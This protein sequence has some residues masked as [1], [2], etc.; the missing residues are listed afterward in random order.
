MQKQGKCTYLCC[1]VVTKYPKQVNVKHGLFNSY[2]WSFKSMMA[3][4]SQFRWGTTD[5]GNT[6]VKTQARGTITAHRK[7]ERSNFTLMNWDPALL[8]VIPYCVKQCIR[9]VSCPRRLHLTNKFWV[10]VE[11]EGR[12]TNH[13]FSLEPPR[14]HRLIKWDCR[15][16]RIYQINQGNQNQ[17]LTTL[18][19]PR[20][21]LM[22]SPRSIKW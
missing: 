2:F 18:T 10:H 17:E 14:Q 21:K 19:R 16:K 3:E 6:I 12:P 8:Y 22:S 13:T 4:F 20:K 9:P 5:D 11:E 15:G 1:V 7:T